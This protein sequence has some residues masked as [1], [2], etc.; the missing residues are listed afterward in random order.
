LAERFL[1]GVIDRS[2]DQA[3]TLDLI[4]EVCCDLLPISVA[5]VVLMGD[6]GVEGITGASGALAVAIQN[7]EFTLGEGPA[8]DVRRQRRPVLVSDLRDVTS[9]WPRFAPAVDR[10][11]VRAIYAIPLRI[12]AIDLGVLVL[13]AA[14]SVAMSGQELTDSVLLGDLVSR[15][16]LD[17][18]A[19]VTSE[20]LAWALDS[21][22]SRAV[23]HQ[24]TGMI[25]AQLNI[26]VTE[27]LVRLRANAFATDR[28]IVEAATDVVAGRRR[29]EEP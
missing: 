14:Q 7:E 22:D 12:G 1:A 16:V 6:Q 13:G 15:L 21:T 24:A 26:G 17:L 9:D 28:P 19:G 23:V 5:S 10:L 29:F 20:S 2:R 27:A 11:G 3:P 18:Q 25:A 8:T 4:C